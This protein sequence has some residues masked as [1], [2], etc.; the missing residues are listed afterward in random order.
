MNCHDAQS[1]MHGYLDGELDL[2]GSLQC[3]QHLRECSACAKAVAEQQTL[4]AALKADTLYYRAPENLRE[5]LRSTLRKQGG[6][7]A[8]RFPW[9]LVAAAACVVFFMGLGFVLAQFTLAPAARERLTQEV[10][11]AHIRSLQA[12]HIVDVLSSDRH[13][14]K[15][16][17]NGKLDFAPLT[18]DLSQHGFSLVGGRLDYINGRTVA[19]VVYRRREHLINVFIWPEAGNEEGEIRREALQGYQL[20]H[21]SRNGMQHWVVSDLDPGQLNEL[22]ERLRE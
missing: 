12:E 10:A 16:W 13:T 7:R 14:V 22:V 17:F 1:L 4:Q 18:R 5:R 8:A 21:W 2:G 20:V 9:R 6:P 11:S 15:P 19:A 3:E